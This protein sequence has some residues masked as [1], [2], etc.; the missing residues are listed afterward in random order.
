LKIEVIYLDTSALVKRY[1]EERGSD[2]IQGLFR[3]ENVITSKVSY[4]EALA[5]FSRRRR[6]GFIPPDRYIYVCSSFDLEWEAYTVV[7]LSDGILKF[8]RELISKHPL[9]ALPAIHL[10]S[11]LI[12]RQKMMFVS[13]DKILLKAAEKESLNVLNPEG[14]P[15]H[16]DNHKG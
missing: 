3:K 4:V 2:V 5:A 16:H 11:A 6:E 1:V 9:R 15:Y 7:E 12:I 14:E 13:S 10:A 8:T